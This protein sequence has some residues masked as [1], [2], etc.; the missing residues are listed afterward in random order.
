M[1]SVLFYVLKFAYSQVDNFFEIWE[2]MN[3]FQG[4]PKKYINLCYNDVVIHMGDN[5][6]YKKE[7][8]VTYTY[9]NKGF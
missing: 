6:K 2:D 5:V 8:F 4:I 7:N 3:I 9:I 1:V